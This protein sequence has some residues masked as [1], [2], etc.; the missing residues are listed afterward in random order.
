M[1]DIAI[2]ADASA[3][4]KFY[5]YIA[6]LAL[7]MG[8]MMAQVQRAWLPERYQTDTEV[9]AN[10]AFGVCGVFRPTAVTSRFAV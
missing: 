2:N 1:N 4:T 7:E 5:H 10:S 9:M 8:W 3:T 6:A